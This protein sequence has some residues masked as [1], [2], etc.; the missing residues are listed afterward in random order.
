LEVSTG[1]STLITADPKAS[2]ANW[3]GDGNEVVWL[4]EGENGNTSFIVTHVGDPRKTY[5]AGTVPGPISS[6]KLAVLEEGR[7]AIAVSGQA[8]PDGTLYNP[9]DVPKSHSTGKLYESLMVRHWDKYIEAQRN[10]IWYGIMQKRVPHVTERK[11]RY[12][13]MGFTNALKGTGLESPIPPFGGTDHFDISKSG[14]VFVAKDPDLDPAT[15][16]KC[17]CYHIPLSFKETFAEDPRPITVAGFEGAATSPVFSPGGKSVAF[18]QMKEDGYES[19]KNRIMIVVDAARSEQGME[20]LASSDGKGEW[21]RSPGS[22]T[23]SNDGKSLLVQAEDIGRG[24]LFQIPLDTSL[25]ATSKVPAKLTKNGYVSDVRPAAS[26]STKLFISS[27]SLID[28]SL[29]SI[30]DPESPSEMQPVSSSSGNGALFGLSQKQVSEIW[31]DGANGHRVH[32]WVVKPS[33]FKKGEKYPLA[34]LIHGG[35]QGAW[36]KASIHTDREASTNLFYRRPMEYQ[37]ESGRECSSTHRLST[38]LT[39]SSSSPNK[40]TSSSPPTQPARQGT[41]NPSLA[42]SAANGAASHT[43]TS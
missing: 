41:A 6:L 22:I 40:A 32:A 20:L 3:L 5:T 24:C 14:L 9:H 28:N 7:I 17:T 8:N 26:G 19:D 21:D 43:K 33:R 42:P 13:L 35:P 11:G 4:K 36:G 29:F 10:T 16:T 25:K 1:Q 38:F 18:L 31:W 2:E 23:W 34:Y 15:H 37:M 39:K 27:T 12:Y 30:L